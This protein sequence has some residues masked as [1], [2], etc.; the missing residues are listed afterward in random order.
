MQRQFPSS[1]RF[2]QEQP[3]SLTWKWHLHDPGLWI[4]QLRVSGHGVRSAR[5][6][7]G[8]SFLQNK[9]PHTFHY[10]S[11]RFFHAWKLVVKREKKRKRERE[12]RRNRPP[13]CLPNPI[14]TE[15][16]FAG[17]SSD[18]RISPTDRVVACQ[19]SAEASAVFRFPCPWPLSRS[20]AL[21]PWSSRSVVEI[22]S[23]RSSPLSSSS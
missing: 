22:S 7:R 21:C 14:R 23:A 16:T 13:R 10:V 5:R 2:L 18:R 1:I 9:I 12:R 8:R 15:C 19:R 4:A 17:S 20:S 3:S 6:K 11:P